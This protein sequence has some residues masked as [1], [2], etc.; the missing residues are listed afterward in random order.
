MR[1]TG[2]KAKLATSAAFPCGMMGEIFEVEVIMNVVGV[3]RA[4][5][6]N[7]EF[8]GRCIRCL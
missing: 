2:G 8:S 3:K 1:I 6:A 7:Q 4:K 5:D